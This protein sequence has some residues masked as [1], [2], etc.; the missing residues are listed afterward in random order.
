MPD[1]EPARKDEFGEPNGGLNGGQTRCHARVR[2][3]RVSEV[4]GERSGA[5]GRVKAYFLELFWGRAGSGIAIR[6][7]G[8][9]AGKVAGI[10]V[11]DGGSGWSDE[12]VIGKLPE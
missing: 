12:K 10:G 1:M 3:R 9:V 7:V 2:Q 8:L 11:S 6:M 4:A 5:C